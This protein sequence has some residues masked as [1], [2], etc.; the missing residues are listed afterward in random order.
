MSKKMYLKPE[1][2]AVYFQH[3]PQLVVTSAKGEDMHWNPGGIPVS[4]EDR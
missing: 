2:K 1:M 3:Q 4:D